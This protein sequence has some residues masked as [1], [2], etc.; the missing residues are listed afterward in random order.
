MYGSDNDLEPSLEALEYLYGKEVAKEI[1]RVIQVTASIHR[2]TEEAISFWR[3]YSLLV[4][5]WILAAGKANHLSGTGDSF[6]NYTL[7]REDIPVIAVAM[8]NVDDPESMAAILSI[9]QVPGHS[10]IFNRSHVGGKG[11]MIAA[12][13]AVTRKEFPKR[14]LKTA[15]PTAVRSGQQAVEKARELRNLKQQKGA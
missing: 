4:N 8:E 7:R 14:K 2:N 13:M 12:E 15:P 10:M 3:A 9:E 11:M 1:K 5:M 6:L